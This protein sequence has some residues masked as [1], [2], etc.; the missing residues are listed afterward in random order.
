MAAS[1]AI[2]EERGTHAR[3]PHPHPGYYAGG[4]GRPGTGARCRSAP[5]RPNR[6]LL[7]QGSREV[8]RR[9]PS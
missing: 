3:S 4:F 7:E 2:E 5:S 1:L 6:P 8:A 9:Q